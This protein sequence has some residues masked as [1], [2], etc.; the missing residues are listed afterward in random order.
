MHRKL[1]N[2]RGNVIKT[3]FPVICCRTSMYKKPLIPL[4]KKINLLWLNEWLIASLLLR[5]SSHHMY[6]NCNGF[7]EWC[8]IECHFICTPLPFFHV[9]HLLTSSIEPSSISISVFQLSPV[10]VDY[11]TSSWALLFLY[12]IMKKKMQETQHEAKYKTTSNKVMKLFS[13]NAYIDTRGLSNKKAFSPSI[14]LGNKVNWTNF[15]WMLEQ[16]TVK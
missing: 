15:S 4:L 3:W 11:D 12:A 16:Q 10:V 6:S 14:F 9:I 7:Y 13:N 5:T 1:V 8:K 2:K